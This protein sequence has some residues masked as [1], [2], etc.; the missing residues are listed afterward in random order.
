[1]TLAK[2]QSKTSHLPLRPWL[3]QLYIKT[4]IVL[5]KKIKLLLVTM[6]HFFAVNTSTIRQKTKLQT[7]MLLQLLVNFDVPLCILRSNF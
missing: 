2:Q 4:D 5:G 7:V 1:M 6:Q 3:F